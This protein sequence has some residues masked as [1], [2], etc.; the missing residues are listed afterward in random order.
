MS[1]SALWAAKGRPSTKSRKARMASSWL[2]AP[3][4]ISS[5]MPVSWMMFG[6]QGALGI[7]KGLEALLHFPVFQDD[8]ADLGD[9]LRLLVQACRLQVKADDGFVQV[10]VQAAPWTVRRSSTSLM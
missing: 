2:G 8:R 10:L 1:N 7:D 5:V 9:D 6:G 4:S 3:T